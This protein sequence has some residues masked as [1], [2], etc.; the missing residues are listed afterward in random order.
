MSSATPLRLDERYLIVHN[1]NPDFPNE[2]IDVVG[3]CSV[4]L[5]RT[6]DDAKLL[7]TILNRQKDCPSVEVLRAVI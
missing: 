3:M 1:A 5:L 4:A 6:E 2:V 7:A